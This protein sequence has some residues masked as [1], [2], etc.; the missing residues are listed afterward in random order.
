VALEKTQ[1]H[2]DFCLITQREDKSGTRKKY[3]RKSGKKEQI[4]IYLLA[5]SSTTSNIEKISY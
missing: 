1:L 2:I 4:K 5:I 3:E